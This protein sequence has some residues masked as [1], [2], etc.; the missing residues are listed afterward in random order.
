M[1]RLIT[2]MLKGLVAVLPIGLTVYLL[3][4]ILSTAES[5]AKPLVLLVVPQDYYFPGLGLATSLVLLAMIGL[6][7]NLYGVRY[8]MK[9]S[10]RIFERIPLVKSIYGAIRDMMTVFN[11]S[12]KQELQS[13]VSLEIQGMQVIGFVT[14]EKTGQR[15]FGDADLVG[16][17]LPLSYQIGG[18][19]VYVSREKLT[20]LDLT[21]EEGMRIA[22][23]GGVQSTST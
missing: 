20:A 9:L 7:V 19:T 4:W 14:G 22:V 17:Y 23:T 10:H 11:L 3:F 21:M 16:V 18:M 8:L 15:L 12:K 13:V 6:F 1:N 2:L 5:L